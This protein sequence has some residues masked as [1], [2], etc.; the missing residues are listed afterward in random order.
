MDLIVLVILDKLF[1]FSGRDS[2]IYKMKAILV[3]TSR[4]VMGLDELVGV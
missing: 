3:L 4:V 1:N 2:F